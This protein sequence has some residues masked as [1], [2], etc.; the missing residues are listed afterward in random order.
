MKSKQTLPK[1]K[2]QWLSCNSVSD[3]VSKLSALPE[4]NHRVF[5]DVVQT[6]SEY[7]K[8]KSELDALLSLLSSQIS[9]A[10]AYVNKN[11]TEEEIAS[12]LEAK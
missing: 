9:D 4:M 8:K 11:W 2:K 7:Q 10:V 5:S 3:A 1:A 6:M 12:A